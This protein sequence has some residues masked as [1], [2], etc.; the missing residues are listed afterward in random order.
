MMDRDAAERLAIAALGWLAGE[1]AE[2][3]RFL[4]ETGAGAEDL[5]ARAVEPEF[6]GFVLDFMMA[7]DDR[8]L[9]FAEAEGVLPDAAVR[10]R[11]ALPGG[12]QPHWT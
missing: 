4:A 12:Q 7:S 10:A 5:R 3:T 1:E 9:A 2:L 6:L 8:L 11:A